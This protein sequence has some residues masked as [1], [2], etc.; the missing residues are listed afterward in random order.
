[1]S[2]LVFKARVDPLV[3]CF[4]EW[5]PQLHLWCDTCGV[6]VLLKFSPKH[7]ETGSLGARESEV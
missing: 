3:A 4:I 7:A 2:A 6:L 1:M 5:I